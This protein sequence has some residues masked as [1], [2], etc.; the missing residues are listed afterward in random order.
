MGLLLLVVIVTLSLAYFTAPLWAWFV[1]LGL[2]LLG[3][4]ASVLWWIPVVV[5]AVVF[6]IKKVR[7][8]LIIK[9]LFAML[10]AKGLLYLRYPT[11]KKQH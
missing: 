8:Q 1:V 5:L 6:L 7:V 9:P 3:C 2:F 10:K 11:Q 4:G